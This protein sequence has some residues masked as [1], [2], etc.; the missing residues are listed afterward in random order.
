MSGIEGVASA[1]QGLAGQGAAAQ[2][3]EASVDD[4]ARLEAAM[5]H[6]QHAPA[7]SGQM[8]PAQEVQPNQE[9]QPVT[10][11]APAAETPGDRILDSLSRMSQGYDS[12]IKEVE[13]TL[14]S[15]QPGEMMNSAD[16]LRLQFAITQVG[17]QQDVTGKV[18]GR[19]T[20]NLDQFLKNQ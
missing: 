9:V 19:A 10:N 4:V 18:V 16:L 8:P 12:A 6:G 14:S 13:Q 5:Q 15:M 1:L 20:Q 2:P 17:V 3:T 7:G 11:A